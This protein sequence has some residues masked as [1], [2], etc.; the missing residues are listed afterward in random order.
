ME[1]YSLKLA[2]DAKLVK[3]NILFKLFHGGHHSCNLIF[4]IFVVEGL[5]LVLKDQINMGL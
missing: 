1:K 4:T 5:R 3:E 2:R